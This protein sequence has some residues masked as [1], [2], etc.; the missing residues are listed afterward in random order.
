M[1]DARVYSY[2]SAAW[3]VRPHISA[4]N[5]QRFKRL[6]N[7][8]QI[9]LANE[10]RGDSKIH[11]N[12][13]L[14]WN[15]IFSYVMYWIVWHIHLHK[16]KMRNYCIVRSTRSPCWHSIEMKGECGHW[17]HSQRK[18]SCIGIFQRKDILHSMHT[19]LNE[20]WWR[21]KLAPV[22]FLFLVK[23]IIVEKKALR[24]WF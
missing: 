4:F 20:D 5:L 22:R 7:G 6:F 2:Q 13:S 16:N 3:W 10:I 1:C 9:A 18:I 21:H 14:I 17:T 24:L 12:V 11:S 19:Q 23:I 15:W 8:C